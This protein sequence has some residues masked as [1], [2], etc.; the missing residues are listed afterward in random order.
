MYSFV[1]DDFIKS[2]NPDVIVVQKYRLSADETFR[3]E[4]RG[5]V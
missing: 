5:T 4:L 2:K 3:L 1:P